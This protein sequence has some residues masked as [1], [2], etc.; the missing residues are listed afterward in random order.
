MS[1]PAT[2]EEAAPKGPWRIFIETEGRVWTLN[3]A[4][5]APYLGAQ[6]LLGEQRDPRA[7]L[8]VADDHGWAQFRW[9]EVKFVRCVE[10]PPMLE[11]DLV[12][13]D[14][15]MDAAAHRQKSAKSKLLHVEGGGM[16]I[17]GGDDDDDAPP[18]AFN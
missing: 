5:E 15:D 10:Y 12:Y 18:A 8:K 4:E 7:V 16:I 14:L 13:S 9:E 1:E 17:L 6:E 2:P 11:R 3:Y